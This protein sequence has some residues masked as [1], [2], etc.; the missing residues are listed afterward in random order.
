MDRLEQLERY[1]RMLATMNTVISGVSRS[2]DLRQLL[3]NALT[4][5]IDSMG[6][7]AGKI[8][9]YDAPSRTVTLSGAKGSLRDRVEI[10]DSYE[11][12]EIKYSN[13]VLVTGEALVINDSRSIPEHYLEAVDPDD[14]KIK[15]HHSFAILPLFSRDAVIGVLNV[16][17]DHYAPFDEDDLWLL[18]SIADH[19]AVAL[20]N[21]QLYGRLQEANRKLKE[22]DRMKSA[23]FTS[24]SHDLHAPIASI[25]GYSRMLS[26]GELGQL[27]AGQLDAARIISSQGRFLLG[28]I[29][30]IIDTARLEAGQA[31]LESTEFSMKEVTKQLL[32]DIAPMVNSGT[33][34]LVDRVPSGL[35]CARGDRKRVERILFNLVSNALK[36]TPSGEVAISAEDRNGWINVSVIDTGVGIPASHLPLI[37]ERFY[38]VDGNASRGTQGAGLG[39][40][41]VKELVELHG[42]SV[43]VESSVG[44]GTTFT[45]TLPTAGA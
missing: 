14:M 28:L 39:L 6:L 17:H 8:L 25:L 13:W 44:C 26:D 34:A 29:D 35:P 37:F 16:A 43:H 19:L 38:R 42:G 15:P 20:I 7:S 23:F 41:I 27:G 40:S 21:S 18:G 36:F 32:D 5:I 30:D 31:I 9:V 12:S 33:V 4:T 24:I 45:F 3:D 10:G 1:N 2:I 22:H 11:L